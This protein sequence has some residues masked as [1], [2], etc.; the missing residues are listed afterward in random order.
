MLGS[1]PA[2]LALLPRSLALLERA[3]PVTFASCTFTLRRSRNR[4]AV[5]HLLEENADPCREDAR[6]S[7]EERVIRN[8][9]CDECRDH[10]SRREERCHGPTSEDPRLHEDQGEQD[11]GYDGSE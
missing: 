8:R 1:D 7:D 2:L 9:I 10:P 5:P 6:R 11:Q 4:D 3:L